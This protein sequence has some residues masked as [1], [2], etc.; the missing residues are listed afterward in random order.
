MKQQQQQQQ[1]YEYLSN[2]QIETFQ[3]DGV[4]VVNN[5]LSTKDI[6]YYKNA[7][8]CTLY[9]RCGFEMDGYTYNSR[10]DIVVADDSTTST[11]NSTTCGG[12][13]S[14]VQVDNENTSIPIHTP[15]STHTPTPNPTPIPTPNPTP[16]PT[17][18]PNITNSNTKTKM[19][20]TAHL[21]SKLSS[22][23]G[24]GGVLDIFDTKW[25]MKLA[26]NDLIYGMTCDLWKSSYTSSYNPHYENKNDDNDENKNQDNYHN[27]NNIDN[28]NNT[29][30]P[31]SSS[32]SSPSSSSWQQHSYGSFNPN[33]GFAYIDRIGYRLPTIVAEKVGK[34]MAEIAGAAAAAADV[35][36]KKTTKEIEKKNLKKN[37]NYGGG[38]GCKD[39]KERKEKK[40]LE[41]LRS[42]EKEREKAQTGVSLN[43]GIQKNVIVKKNDEG[44]IVMV[45]GSNGIKIDNSTKI[46]NDKNDNK[47]LALSSSSSILSNNPISTL[48]SSTTV[49]EN[50]DDNNVHMKMKDDHSKFKNIQSGKNNNQ[51]SNKSTLT[52]SKKKKKKHR[53]LQRCLT[54]HFDCCPHT[55]YQQQRTIISNNN[56]NNINDNDNDNDRSK[57]ENQSQNRNRWRPIQSLISFTDQTLPNQGG[58]E[59]ALGFHREFDDWVRRSSSSRSLASHISSPSPSQQHSPCLGEYSPIRPREDREILNRVGHVAVPAGSI[60]FWD[61]R[62]PHGSEYVHN[63]DK[64]TSDYHNTSDV[65]AEPR[66]VAYVSFLPAV[67]L[68]RKYAMNR[69]ERMKKG[70]LEGLGNGCIIGSGDGGGDSSGDLW[71]DNTSSKFVGDDRKEGGENTSRDDPC[72]PRNDDGC[73]DIVKEKDLTQL[74]KKLL[75]IDSW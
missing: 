28:S 9:N 22:T 3:R 2:E 51:P 17:P 30:S 6:A 53:P 58:F 48:I 35:A 19:E 23:N 15:N 4:L 70:L 33:E 5:V 62:I 31:S 24:S 60:V 61:V 45:S 68:N 69:V 21:L 59:A 16:N 27:N 12:E 10:N 11:E 56:N 8:H 55:F 75:C 37:K 52:T 14:H 71:M 73:N 29:S 66:M 54:P 44:I 47:V 49:K 34:E 65:G 72:L 42:R 26:T 32:S 64:T 41:R 43:E 67:E 13:T 20:Q 38:K 63:G 36:V 74:G 50:N 57:D 1:Q 25:Q 39:R 46:S 18:I 40:R 7:L